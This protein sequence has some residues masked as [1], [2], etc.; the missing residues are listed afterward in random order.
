MLIMINLVIFSNF[1]LQYYL[2]FSY[3]MDVWIW[4][5]GS[6][7]INILNILIYT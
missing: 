3:I 6:F 5:T 1:D 4:V 7:I 2:F